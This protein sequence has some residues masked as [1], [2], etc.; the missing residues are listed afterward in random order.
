WGD[1]G[2]GKIVDELCRKFDVVVRYQGGNNAGHTVVADGK[3]FKLHL[4]PS[5]LVSGKKSFIASSVVI[6][7][8]VLLDEIS[9]LKATPKLLGVDFRVHVIMPWHKYLDA[10]RDKGKDKIGTTGR[11]IGPVY[12]SHASRWG[13]RVEELVD[14][15]LL[16]EALGRSY[17]VYDK[18]LKMVYG[19]EA[20]PSEHEIFKEYAEMGGKL[21][22]F[23]ADV[24]I[25]VNEALDK[26]KR[27]LFEGAQGV[28]L[29]NNF[30]T[31]PYVT[32]SQP[33]AG[34]VA[35]SV[36]MCPKKLERIEAVVKAY[37]TR[38]GE[39]PF[40]TELQGEE[41]ERLREKG[42][43][44]GTTTGRPRRI[45]WLDLTMINLGK[46]LNGY[47][48]LHLTKLDV[49]G[50]TKKL[51]VCTAYKLDSQKIDYFP[52]QKEWISKAEP[53]Y[54]ELDG[55][56]DLTQEEWTELVEASN[57]KGLAALPAKA[58]EYVEKIQKLTSLKVVSVSV[59]PERHKT[60][61]L[62]S[63]E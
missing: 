38:V 8:K 14:E 9:G 5:G 48:A 32:S 47:T 57:E 36:G 59:G 60:L 15:S 43:E 50:G 33:L 49:L 42:G 62:E 44:F 37:T 29:D 39:G 26:G 34:N 21:K 11:G 2:K 22:P 6:D 30:G 40:P 53:Q 28:M 4:V 25:E 18:T 45:G 63:K 7:P 1:E 13:I 19:V 12:E 58:R 16:K 3:K 31:Y 20:M 41:A 27:V 51:K 52:T 23:V 10:E 56:E 24:S 46:R 55:F 61:L 17:P 35:A 54:I